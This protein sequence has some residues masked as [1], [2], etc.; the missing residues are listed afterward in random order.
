MGFDLTILQSYPARLLGRAADLV[1]NAALAEDNE[2]IVREGH[3][4]HQSPDRHG[5]GVGIG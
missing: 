2:G 4:R 3:R 5:A 1:L